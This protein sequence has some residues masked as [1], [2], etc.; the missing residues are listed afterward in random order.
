MNPLEIIASRHVRL[1]KRTKGKLAKV[2]CVTLR[3][4]VHFSV[5]S[6]LEHSRRTLK[7]EMFSKEEL[8][9]IIRAIRNRKLLFSG[10]ESFFPC[11]LPADIVALF[12]ERDITTYPTLVLLSRFELVR[13]LV[14]SKNSNVALRTKHLEN[15][16][17]RRGYVLRTDRES[18]DRLCSNTIMRQAVIEL[19]IQGL[20]TIESVVLS[21]PDPWCINPV[22]KMRLSRKIKGNIIKEILVAY[23]HCIY[24]QK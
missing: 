22:G 14:D 4:I 11:S 5:C 17:E 9:D 1:R 18:L 2:E 8:G 12:W 19:Y 23:C 16:L 21:E 3:G 20:R 6:F 13:M 10:K 24:Q 7:D 15:E